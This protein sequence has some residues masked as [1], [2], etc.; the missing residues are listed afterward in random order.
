MI[1]LSAIPASRAQSFSPFILSGK[2]SDLA[3]GDISFR[4][5]ELA[6]RKVDAGVSFGKWMPGQLNYS[7]IQAGGF[8][9]I[10]EGFGIRLDYRNNLY[11]EFP[12]IDANGNEK[13][14]VKPSEQRIMAGVSL[15]LNDN[16]IID[17]NGKYLSTAMDG[18]SGSAFA[19]DVAFNYVK[20]GL[21]VGLKGADIGT[22]YKFG[23]TPYALPMRVMAGGSYR[24]A[25]GEKHAVTLAA[26]LGYILPKEYGAFT[27]ALGTE[28][29]F[30]QMI[31][32]RAGYHF[33]SSVAPRFASFGLGFAFKGI[34]LDAAYL[35]GP[36][37]NA[38]TAGLHVTL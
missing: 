35:L 20:D 28:Y 16:I 25:P 19:G 33:S 13:G 3:V 22:K 4:T 5:P 18:A 32:A 34:G 2:A 38:W 23:D 26:D 24:I 17:V 10:S 27:A 12:R 7:A 11:P 14:T 8:L 15:R 6:S 36:S 37:G 30:N 9:A 21:T 1:A 31:Y 29:A